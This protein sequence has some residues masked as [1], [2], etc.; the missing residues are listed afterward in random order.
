L[1]N[2]IEGISF[3]LTEVLESL[4]LLSKGIREELSSTTN[5]LGDGGSLSFEELDQ[6]ELVVGVVDEV[7]LLEFS[8]LGGIESSLF[9][10]KGVVEGSSLGIEGLNECVVVVVEGIVEG[11]CISGKTVVEGSPLAAETGSKGSSSISE[12]LILSGLHVSN[13]SFHSGEVFFDASLESSFLLIDQGVDLVL[14]VWV[15]VVE[16]SLEILDGVH[17]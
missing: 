6:M 16:L 9:L 15:S 4:L 10:S 12:G 13:D 11:S 7:D 17:D 5:C 2:L 8:G 1:A 14:G 3:L